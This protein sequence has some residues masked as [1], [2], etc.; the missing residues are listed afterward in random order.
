[1][2]PPP[3]IDFEQCCIGSPHIVHDSFIV[4]HFIRERSKF[5]DINSV[6]CLSFR[7]Q[8]PLP[9]PG[10]DKRIGEVILLL[11]N[12]LRFFFETILIN[13][14]HTQMS[15][16]FSIEKFFEE[17]KVTVSNL[18]GKWVCPRTVFGWQQPLAVSKIVIEKSPSRG[19]L[20][21]HY[22]LVEIIAVG[23]PI[24]NKPGHV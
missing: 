8:I 19:K 11:Q 20:V 18:D 3:P 5:I 13:T 1:K 21:G 24:M 23:D 6:C 14:G 2:H 22:P 7:N 12:D 9:F 10:K 4:T 15:L 17:Q 16:I